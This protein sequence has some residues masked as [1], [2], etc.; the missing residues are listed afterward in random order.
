MTA[1]TA[2]MAV[3][4]HRQ[5]RAHGKL[6]REAQQHIDGDQHEGCNQRPGSFD[7]QFLAHLRAHHFGALQSDACIDAVK[8]L[9]NMRANHLTLHTG[10]R[11]QA[12]Q[13]IARTAEGLH[14]RAAHPCGAERGAQ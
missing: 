4:S 11:R 3:R 9:E 7:E 8:D 1:S 14:L 10:I 6:R 13:D 2:E 5:Y 12:H